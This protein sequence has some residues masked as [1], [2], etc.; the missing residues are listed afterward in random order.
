MKEKVLGNH[1]NIQYL[2][3]ALIIHIF[4]RFFVRDKYCFERTMHN[5]ELLAKE[6]NALLNILSEAKKEDTLKKLLVPRTSMF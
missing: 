5:E 3:S 6:D 1:F 2:I 4:V